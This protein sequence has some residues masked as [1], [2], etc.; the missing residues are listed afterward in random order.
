MLRA[1]LAAN[2]E[3]EIVGEAADGSAAIEQ[4]LELVPDVIVMDVTMPG[5][6]GI[7]ATRRITEVRPTIRVVA[8]AGS[9]DLDDVAAMLEA[10]ADDYCVKGAPLWELE[11]AV[12]GS[13]DSL[14]RL[15]QSL[16]RALPGSIGALIA[17]ELAKR[18][19]AVYAATCLASSEAGLIVA[20]AAGGGAEAL[21]VVPRVARRAF[22]SAAAAAATPRE[23][24]ELRRLGIGCSGALAVPLVV[25][26]IRLG[27]LVVATPATAAAEVDANVV[28]AVAD[29]A[30]AALAHE[31]RVALSH[32]E[33]RRDP[34]T[35][36]LN[37]RAFDE[38]FDAAFRAAAGGAGRVSIAL[39]DLDGFK[40][41]NDANGHA[42]GD[43]VLQ[44]VARTLLQA[45]RATEDVFR[46]G[47]DEFVLL[48]HGD[49]ESAS[50][51]AERA[52][53][54]LGRQRRGRPLP[55]LS[56]GV[57]GSLAGETGE[58]LLERADIAL[59][60]AK[61]AGGDAVRCADPHAGPTEAP[62]E[63]AAR[64]GQEPATPDTVETGDRTHARTSRA[65][66]RLSGR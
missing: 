62:P 66:G 11:R 13:G 8:F 43:D 41:V 21:Q 65:P 32:A 38:Q 42:A 46:T 35:G 64:G 52:R 19:G 45:T 51:A 60:A 59:Y 18:T 48:V 57:A 56:A 15:A 34:L 24:E 50:R 27:A 4:A 58:S 9:D 54:A 7:A 12:I 47:G 6:D 29:L 23:L 16:S 14:V 36:L 2:T 3:I 30:A 63:R 31:R 28:A 22:A 26:G 37:R 55:T 17:R 25:Q 61:L 40:E 1:G 10:G 44:T 33:A 49:V 5:L 39:L 53:A 20:G